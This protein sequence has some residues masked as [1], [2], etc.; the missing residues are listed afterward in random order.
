MKYN[1]SCRYGF[2]RFPS[3]RTLVA[4][5][6]EETHPGIGEKEKKCFTFSNT[7]KLEATLTTVLR[8]YYAI[9]KDILPSIILKFLFT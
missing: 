7:N 8:K 2:P 3:A 9:V 1:G 6:I 5:P 4:K